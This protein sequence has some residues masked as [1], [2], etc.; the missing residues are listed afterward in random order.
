MSASAKKKVFCAEPFP[1]VC[2]RSQKPPHARADDT[3][4]LPSVSHRAMSAC[5][6]EKQRVTLG[7]LC[8]QRSTRSS[9]LSLCHRRTGHKWQ[10]SPG[11][12]VCARLSAPRHLWSRSVA[13]IALA[14]IFQRNRFI[15]SSAR[16]P[17][18]GS[19]F[20]LPVRQLFGPSRSRLVR[21]QECTV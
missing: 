6:T 5:S 21:I 4:D 1:T 7:I 8:L 20:F 17:P 2:F 10:P 3:A 15:P 19:V 16:D 14:T 13:G 11:W 18:A 12:L 9:S